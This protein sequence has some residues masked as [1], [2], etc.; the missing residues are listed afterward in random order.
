ML[1][2]G[3]GVGVGDVSFHFIVTTTLR[4]LPTIWVVL[5]MHFLVVVVKSNENHQRAERRTPFSLPSA[6]VTG[7]GESQFG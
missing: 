7:I 5:C 3:V 1:V 4:V 2:F 6:D